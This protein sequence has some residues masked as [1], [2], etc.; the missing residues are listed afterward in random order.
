[1]WERITPPQFLEIPGASADGGPNDIPL[2]NP[3]A[4]DHKDG[5]VLTS[6]FT[7]HGHGTGLLKSTDC[8]S[9]WTRIS[10]GKNGDAIT[11]GSLWSLHIDPQ[12]PDVIYVAA[13]YGSPPSLFKSTNG[14]VDWEDL[15]PPGSEAA[16][17]LEQP[18]FVQGMG[19]DPT[20]PQHL[21]VTFHTNC[22]GDLA[23]MC[24]A[25][26]KDG[27]ATF[28]LFKG[29]PA[30]TG[31]GEASTITV[32]GAK[33]WV[34]ASPDLWGAFYTGDGGA[35]W[36]KVITGPAYGNYTGSSFL[37]DDGAL[38]LGVANTGIFVSR[39]TPQDPLGTTWT[40]IPG[41]PQ[42]SSIVGDDVTLFASY[43]WDTSGQPFYSAPLPAASTWTHVPSADI[44][45]GGADHMDI[46][47]ARHIL[48]APAGHDVYRVVM[49]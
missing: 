1:V 20:D 12:D 36:S 44:P 17:R 42:A 34:Y 7:W 22:T 2:I 19:M 3:I 48:Y 24:M 39:A 30:A 33:S 6:G 46:D 23:P 29:P 10:T 9:T 37:A 41:S 49:R 40:L 28:R 43:G 26:S 4:V 8:G 14:G 27:G 31:W 5:S 18:S 32:I 45:A 35:T 21:V 38:Y 25:E 15:F 13:G 11:A 47:R 16:T